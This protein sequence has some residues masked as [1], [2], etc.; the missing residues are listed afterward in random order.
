MEKSEQ[1]L[2]N[3]VQKQKERQGNFRIFSLISLS[4]KVVTV[5]KLIFVLRETVLLNFGDFLLKS[6][7][8]DRDYLR[9]TKCNIPIMFLRRRNT[10]LLK[11]MKKLWQNKFIKQNSKILTRSMR[12]MQ[13]DR[14]L[15]RQN[16]LLKGSNKIFL[17][18][19]R[20]Q[21]FSKLQNGHMFYGS[22]Y[23]LSN[24]VFSRYLRQVEAT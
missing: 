11:H 22:A 24:M 17:R 19:L 7:N 5:V 6:I 14:N 4:S 20:C 3:H 23:V 16:M 8:F 13:F 21:H 12:S 10:I 2:E 1:M 18:H 15:M 9:Y